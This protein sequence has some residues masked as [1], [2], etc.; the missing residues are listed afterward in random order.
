MIDGVKG[1]IFFKLFFLGL[2]TAH[3]AQVISQYSTYYE[4][5]TDFSTYL[6][7]N[8][9]ATGGGVCIKKERHT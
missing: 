5:R 3:N 2:L 7:F 1:S 6:F 4:M 8:E 9:K